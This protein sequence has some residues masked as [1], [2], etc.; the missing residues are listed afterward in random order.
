[1]KMRSNLESYSKCQ[2]IEADNFTFTPSVLSAADKRCLLRI[3]R[4]SIESAL[5]HGTGQMDVYDGDLSK[6]AGA[7]VTLR[8]DA[9][10]R[11]C[12]G[13][14]DSQQ[15]LAET[16]REAAARAALEDPRFTPVTSE[17]TARLEIEISVLSALRRIGSER[18][19][20]IGVHGLVVEALG[21]RGLLLPQVAVQYGWDQPT[22]LRQTL[23]K[24]GLP[25]RMKGTIEI[26]MYVFTAEVFDERALSPNENH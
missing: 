10:L 7:F 13:F 23:R 19:I 4:R 26:R 1:M 11:G 14:I 15:S 20:I 16:V 21:R 6:P 2:Y 12:I 9:E 17:E 18:E 3:A 8:E 24:T 22:F 5:T 25:S